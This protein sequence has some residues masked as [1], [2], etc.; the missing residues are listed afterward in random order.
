MKTQTTIGEILEGNKIFVPPYQRAYSWDTE[1]EKNKPPKHVNTF[2]VDLND[3]HNGSP[4]SAYYFGH[5]LFERRNANANVFGVID[6][7]Q[8]LTTLVIFLAAIFQRLKD[9][10]E[11]NNDNFTRPRD[12]IKHRL[13]YNFST[14]HDDD[15]VLRDYVIER[16]KTRRSGIDTKSQ[17]RIIDAFKH[18]QEMLQNKDIKYISKMLGTLK[19]SS[20]TTHVITNRSQAI[21]MFIFQNNRG[22]KPSNLEIIKAQFMY[23][24]HLN[25]GNEKES[26]LDQ[27]QSR[28][29]KIYRSISSIEDFI[30]EDEVLVH[31]LRVHFNS[32]WESN[33]IER[34][35]K[36]LASDRP[37]DFII[38]FTRSLADSFDYLKEFYCTDQR[39]HLSIH[40]IISLGHI[41]AAIPF[42]IK[43]YVAEIPK[44]DLCALCSSLESLI[45]RHRLIKTRAII[46]SRLDDVY[47]RFEPGNSDI[48]PIIDRVQ[49]L[50]HDTR[51]WWAFWNNDALAEAIKG[52]VNSS[53]AKFMLWKYENH[54]LKS[55]YHAG[56]PQ[57]RFDDIVDPELEHIA[58]KTENTKNGYDTYDS[59]FREKYIECFGNYLLISKSH[60]GSVGNKPFAKKWESYDYLEQ[61][62][63]IRRMTKENMKWTKDHIATR[64]RKI[65]E[66]IR[67]YF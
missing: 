17:N 53:L 52:S 29:E 20:C 19:R 13:L 43:S 55:R 35:T 58:P 61:Q 31:T 67:Q 23:S 25:G 44:S 46:T 1:L 48:F 36:S 56:Y 8:R 5:F 57:I 37:I 3:Y 7:Q 6:G 28:F 24:I 47:K 10:L 32:L 41:S 22:K 11:S 33:A 12:T 40:S 39:G 16:T 2:L 27:L 21:Q 51:W 34:T 54:L 45:V 9:I 38:S 49:Q 15:Q 42:V 64:Q 18:F 63:E 59:D 60:N 30:D 4:K 26:L 62:R 50:R 14:V 65:L 66:F